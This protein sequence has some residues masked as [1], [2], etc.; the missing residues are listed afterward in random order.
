[1][2][3]N[4]IDKNINDLHFDLGGFK[5]NRDKYMD[6]LSLLMDSLSA[7]TQLNNL[8]MNLIALGPWTQSQSF[9]SAWNTRNKIQRALHLSD[10]SSSNRAVIHLNSF[11]LC[12]DY[13]NEITRF[14]L[15]FQGLLINKPTK[16]QF[17]IEL[18]NNRVFSQELTNQVVLH[19]D[20][21]EKIAFLEY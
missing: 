4:N 15:N 17:N 5:R 12:Y 20:S 9:V 13:S 11:T 19:L 14:L 8:S 6:N 1:V 2:L 18:M 21:A 7:F 16:L 3:L 10:N